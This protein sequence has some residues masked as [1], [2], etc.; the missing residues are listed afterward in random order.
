M[1]TVLMMLNVRLCTWYRADRERNSSNS[2]QNESKF[3]HE[4]YSLV[5]FLSVQKMAKASAHV[6]H[7][8]MKLV[9]QE[10]QLLRRGRRFVAPRLR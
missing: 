6:K 5:R 9:V 10:E 8:F 7:I 3:S 1:D 4:H 2:G